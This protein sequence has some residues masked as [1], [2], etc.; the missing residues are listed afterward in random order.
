MSFIK[1]L[2][3]WPQR[4]RTIF[5]TVYQGYV[6]STWHH[7]WC[8]PWLP[9]RGNIWKFLHYEVTPP[10][11][12]PQSLWKEF[13]MCSSYLGSKELCLPS[14]RAEYLH[15]LFET[16]LYGRFGPSSP[17]CLGIQS[18]ID[19]R[20][21]SWIC[22]FKLWVIIQ[23]KFIC[24]VGSNC[25]NKFLLEDNTT[26]SFVI[27]RNTKVISVPIKCCIKLFFF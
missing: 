6:L 20:M 14:S 10:S 25:S 9:G 8:W 23:Y 22:I 7:Y 4:E 2:G 5:I 13:T 1:H 16:L 27:T 15:K 17:I 12:Q 18:F 21:Y 19:I 3:G 24:F 11:V 26:C